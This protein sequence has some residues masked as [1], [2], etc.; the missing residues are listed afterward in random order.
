M[1]TVC[2]QCSCQKTRSEGKVQ[3]KLDS[4]CG[5][6]RKQQPGSLWW[7]QRVQPL[8]F[9]KRTGT[10]NN[11][12]LLIPFHF[13]RNSLGPSG[14]S[15]H[16]QKRVKTPVMNW[17]IKGRHTMQDGTQRGGRSIR[18]VP[19]ILKY[20]SDTS[21]PLLNSQSI[22]TSKDASLCLCICNTPWISPLDLFEILPSCREI[23]ASWSYIT[24]V[25][26]NMDVWD[27][28]LTGDQEEALQVT[29][30]G[31]GKGKNSKKHIY[32][33]ISHFWG[34]KAANI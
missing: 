16:G 10:K 29:K 15:F 19:L 32:L 27:Q 5:L 17:A 18:T 4:D 8:G 34:L 20:L 1:G 12:L 6:E 26:F 2:Y 24:Y 25:S 30:K 23:E 13:V 33:F 21:F 11:L 22:Y 3:G 28:G 14:G 9:T 31:K 7:N